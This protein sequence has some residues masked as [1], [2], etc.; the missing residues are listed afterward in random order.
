MENTM[1]GDYTDFRFIVLEKMKTGTLK[2]FSDI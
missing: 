1:S 2:I